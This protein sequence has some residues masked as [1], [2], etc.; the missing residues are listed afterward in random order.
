MSLSSS[1]VSSNQDSVKILVPGTLEFEATRKAIPHIWLFN[2]VLPQAMKEGKNII[3]KVV[4]G[5]RVEYRLATNDEMKKHWQS[6]E[7]EAV[8]EGTR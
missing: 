4:G 3:T 2:V 7:S 5:N 8:M 1:K 6:G